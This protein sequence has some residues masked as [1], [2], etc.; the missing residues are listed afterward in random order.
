M[1]DTRTFPDVDFVTRTPEEIFSDLVETW[2][3][4]WG[5]SSP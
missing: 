4:R 2:K 1:A 5:G 3:R